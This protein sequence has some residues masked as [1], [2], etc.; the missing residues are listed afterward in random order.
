M[1][2]W[3]AGHPASHF[4]TAHA[5]QA[6]RCSVSSNWEPFRDAPAFNVLTAQF[7]KLCVAPYRQTGNLPGMPPRSIF[8]LLKSANFALPYIGKPGALPVSPRSISL[9]L[10]SANFALPHIGKLGMFRHPKLN[11]VLF[12]G[13]RRFLNLTSLRLTAFLSLCRR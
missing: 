8:L 4:L 13:S 5:Q 9:L 12:A 10:N 2:F 11:L 3:N 7:S 6:S 1:D